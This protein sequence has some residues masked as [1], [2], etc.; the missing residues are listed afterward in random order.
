MLKLFPLQL[1]EA[2]AAVQ[3][4]V[5]NLNITNSCWCDNLTVGA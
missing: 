1:G 2:N 3:F 4:D 5:L